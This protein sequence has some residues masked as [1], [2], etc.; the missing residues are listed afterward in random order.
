MIHIAQL[1]VIQQWFRL[2]LDVEA[3]DKPP[4]PQ[5]II[6]EFS[7]EIFITRHMVHLVAMYTYFSSTINPGQIANQTI[8]VMCTER[9]WQ[10]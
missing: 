9:P 1:T 3:A 10:K 8:T 6:A 4:L 2:S 5:T 7:E